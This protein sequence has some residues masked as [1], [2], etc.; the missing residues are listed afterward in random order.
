MGEEDLLA[1]LQRLVLAKA[2]QQQSPAAEAAS[3]FAKGF[4]LYFLP[5]T[6][7]RRRVRADVARRAAAVGACAAA[8]RLVRRLL[9]AH[10]PL[11][12]ALPSAEAAAGAAAAAA[13]AAVDPALASSVFTLWMAIRAARCLLPRVRGGPTLV[14]CVAA[15]QILTAWVRL[16]DQLD[17]AYLRF[18]DWA[19]G[20]AP[21]MLR[22]PLHLEARG[23]LLADLCATVHPGSASHVAHVP[24]YMAE[25]LARA[26]R[27]YLPLYAALALAKAA[28]RRR[29][30]AAAL[31][32][33]A[34]NVARSSLF[35]ALY[36]VGA[37]AGLCL[38]TLR[39]A[40]A[41]GGRLTLPW[42]Y[43]STFLCGL[44]ALAERPS[45]RVEL[46]AYCLTYAADSWYRMLHKRRLLGESRLAAV[47][48]LSASVACIA[49][50]H[51]QL[52]R[53]VSHWLLS[54]PPPPKPPR[55][56]AKEGA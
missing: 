47:L 4:L 18:L 32:Q 12:R 39:P 49:H 14:M 46:A 38:H 3:G 5:L 35:L 6:L 56:A 27:L 8:F 48:L 41:R 19:G 26:V 29:I 31:L 43:A 51:R 36:C 55:E 50:H 34:E 2:A 20:K 40:A 7:L 25:M 1:R 13:A 21:A 37:W 45:R 22:S 28:H 24:H 9:L 23:P 15:A 54:I 30:D 42:Y 52:P 11:L 16:R 44:A 17:P 10:G 53:I 33:L